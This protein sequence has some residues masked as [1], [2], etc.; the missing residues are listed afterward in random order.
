[1]A[2]ITEELAG[3]LLREWFHRGAIVDIAGSQLDGDNEPRGW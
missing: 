1:M 2:L 3:E